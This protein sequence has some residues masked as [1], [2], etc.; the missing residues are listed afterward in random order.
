M[1]DTSFCVAAQRRG[2]AIAAANF[3]AERRAEEERAG[4]SHFVDTIH[5][6]LFFFLLLLAAAET[7]EREE[8]LKRMQARAEAQ[9]AAAKRVKDAAT[10]AMQVK[11][12]F[13]RWSD[14]VLL[15]LNL[16]FSG[17]EGPTA[18]CRNRWKRE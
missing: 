2:E 14:Y 7:N 13:L 9:E 15:R 10:R 1:C 5:L 4:M 6:S 3:E 16:S 12:V 11:R 17:G 8:A 18:T